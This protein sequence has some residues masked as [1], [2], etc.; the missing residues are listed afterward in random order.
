MMQN[1]ADKIVNRPSYFIFITTFVH[2]ALFDV[3][4]HENIIYSHNA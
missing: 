1:F 3:G 4:L 2:C